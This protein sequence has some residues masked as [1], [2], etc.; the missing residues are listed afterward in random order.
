MFENVYIFIIFLNNQ[1]YDLE[2]IYKGNP[3]SPRVIMTVI[4]EF[5]ELE[6][7]GKIY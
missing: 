3:K 4:K 6:L 1:Y 7:W 2:K 5:V